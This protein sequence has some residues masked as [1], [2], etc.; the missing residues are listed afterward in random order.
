MTASCSQRVTRREGTLHGRHVEGIAAHDGFLLARNLGR[1]P[2]GGDLLLDHMDDQG[3]KLAREEILEL[4]EDRL[5]DLLDR[6]VRERLKLGAEALP[7][8]DLLRELLEDQL[9]EPFSG[10]ISHAMT[11]RDVGRSRAPPLGTCAN[12]SANVCP[13]RYGN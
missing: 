3:P 8:A 4:L 2:F 6:Q 1:G 12:Y 13:K 10:L 9:G 11:E 7:G 5:S